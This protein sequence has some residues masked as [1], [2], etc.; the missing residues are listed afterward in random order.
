VVV[1]QGATPLAPSFPLIPGGLLT[2]VFGAATTAQIEDSA[3]RR[4]FADDGT[5][6]AD[7]QQRPAVA[8]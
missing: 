7:P 1:P 4:L 6:T 2:L 3:G 5:L 8:P